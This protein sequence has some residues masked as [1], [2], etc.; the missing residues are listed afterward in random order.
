MKAARGQGIVSSIVIQSDVRDEID[1]ELVGGDEGHVQTNY[2]GKGWQETYDRGGIHPVTKPMDE[3][4]NYTI[5][6]TPER[7]EF[8][9]EQQLVRTLPY[10]EGKNK[11]GDDNYPQ[12]PS[13]VRIGTWAGGDV[14]NNNE[15]V[16]EWAG[17]PT[18]FSQAPFEMAIKSVKVTDYGPRVLNMDEV[19][20]YVYSDTSGRWQSVQGVG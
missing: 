2:F 8:W 13:F 7:I 18:D 16:V 1:W 15:G 11:D 4:K 12:T 17:G 10:A 9:V 5:D 6:W 19:K 3:Y 14:D 20:E